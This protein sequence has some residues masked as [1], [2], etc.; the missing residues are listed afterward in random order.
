MK[1]LLVSFCLFVTSLSAWGQDGLSPDGSSAG[2]LLGQDFEAVLYHHGGLESNVDAHRI[3]PDEYE[4]DFYRGDSHTTLYFRAEQ[5]VDGIE[6][7]WFEDAWERP[8]MELTFVKRGQK[9]QGVG[10]LVDRQN[11]QGIKVTMEGFVP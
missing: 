11:P 4:V 7:E 9:L 5:G 6:T 1:K 2:A 10:E 3:G 8:F